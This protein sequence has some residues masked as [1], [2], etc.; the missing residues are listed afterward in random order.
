M[1][2]QYVMLV[3]HMLLM[4]GLSRFMRDGQKRTSGHGAWSSSCHVVGKLS[5]CDWV[6]GHFLVIVHCHVTG[7]FLNI[8]DFPSV[9][10][11]EQDGAMHGPL[12]AS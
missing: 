5:L 9:C 10:S 8:C 1:V 11:T 2:S 12:T 6:S 3:K 7:G 4:P